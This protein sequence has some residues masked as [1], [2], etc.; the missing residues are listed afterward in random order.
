M[1]C[2][3]LCPFICLWPQGP[4]YY[5]SLVLNSRDVTVNN[6]LFTLDCQFAVTTMPPFSVA[7]S[8][9]TLSLLH[10]S[11]FFGN[12]DQWKERLDIRSGILCHSENIKINVLSSNT[13]ESY[14]FLFYRAVNWC[15]L[16]TFHFLSR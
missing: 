12:R 14:I 5:S 8:F 16:R 13:I 11:S 3:Q 7:L 15:K 6:A 9:P 1:L 4:L 10:V 2:V